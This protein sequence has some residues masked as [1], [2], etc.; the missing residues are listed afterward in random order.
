MVVDAVKTQCNA[1]KTYGTHCHGIAM[2]AHERSCYP[3]DGS[4]GIDMAVPTASS[5]YCHESAVKGP[6]PCRG[7]S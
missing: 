3:M 5:K 6:W 2:K 4:H 7:M 1:I